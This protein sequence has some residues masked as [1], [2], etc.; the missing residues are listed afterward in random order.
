MRHDAAAV[1]Q[2][3]TGRSNPRNLYATFA[4]G[5]ERHIGVVFEAEF[6]PYVVGALNGTVLIDTLERLPELFAAERALRALSYR[7]AAAE[8]GVSVS[9]LRRLEMGGAVDLSTALG[10]LRWLGWSGAAEP[11][12]PGTDEET[13]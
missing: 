4:D 8:S 2:Y 5:H 7:S 1:A 10:V 3:R 12:T 9:S 6:G 13:A 11:A